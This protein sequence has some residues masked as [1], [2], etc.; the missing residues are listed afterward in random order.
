MRMLTPA[1]LL[2]LASLAVV[3]SDAPPK[4][5]DPAPA[6]RVVLKGA[7]CLDPS[8]ARGWQYVDSHQLLVDAGRRKYRILLSGFCTDL[9]HADSVAFRGDAVSGRVCGHVGERVVLKRMDCRID[10]V[11]LIDADTYDQ[12]ANRRRGTVSGSTGKP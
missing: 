5:S 8:A 1:L 9:G 12:A 11:E 2:S 7:D 4:P 6:R 10:R 3:A